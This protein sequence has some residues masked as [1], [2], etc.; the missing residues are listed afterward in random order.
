MLH[1]RC[2][3]RRL[4]SFCHIACNRNE[5]RTSKTLRTYF[6][7]TCPTSIKGNSRLYCVDSIQIVSF[8]VLKV[9][10]VFFSRAVILWSSE[11]RLQDVKYS[12]LILHVPAPCTELW[13][14]KYYHF[15]LVP[16]R[17]ELM[18][19]P[20]ISARNCIIHNFYFSSSFGHSGKKERK[21]NPF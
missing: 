21:L 2:N 7:K 12:L 18:D 20:E 6:F 9:R 1:F 11:I 10:L 14:Q 15:V 5:T 17:S 8:S 3:F 13:K 16:R 19:V 4:D